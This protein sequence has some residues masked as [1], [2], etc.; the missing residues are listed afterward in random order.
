MVVQIEDN[1][2]HE[3]VDRGLIAIERGRDE[4]ISVGDRQ[5]EQSEMRDTFFQQLDTLKKYFHID[6]ISRKRKAQKIENR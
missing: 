2:D 1:V 3:Q 4:N 5:S 6:R